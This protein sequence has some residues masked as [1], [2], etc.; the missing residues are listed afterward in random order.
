VISYFNHEILHI[1]SKLFTFWTIYLFKH[2]VMLFQLVSEPGNIRRPLAKF[3]SC[4]FGNGASE[5]DKKL[6]YS[7]RR[8]IQHTAVRA[9]FIY[10]LLPLPHRSFHNFDF[11][12][13][14]IPKPLKKFPPVPVHIN[15]APNDIRHLFFISFCCHCTDIA[16]GNTSHLL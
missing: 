4:I 12:H 5:A 9:F 7:A 14:I 15:A 13:D 2:F 1:F 8:T 11:I 6:V 10:Y 16:T 3:F